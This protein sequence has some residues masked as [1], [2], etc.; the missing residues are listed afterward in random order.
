MGYVL[1]T[2]FGTSQGKLLRYTLICRLGFVEEKLVKKTIFRTIL[3]GVKHLT[4]N[5]TLDPDR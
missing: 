5:G 1:Q 3:F 2:G 4:A